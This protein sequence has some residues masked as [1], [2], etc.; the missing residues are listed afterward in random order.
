MTQAVFLQ[1]HEGV[2]SFLIMGGGNHGAQVLVRSY[3]EAWYRE[4]RATRFSRYGDDSFEQNVIAEIGIVHANDK[5]VDSG[6]L[7]AVWSQLLLT[8]ATSAHPE[9]M[10]SSVCTGCRHGGIWVRANLATIPVPITRNLEVGDLTD[11]ELAG[12]PAL[13]AQSLALRHKANAA[14]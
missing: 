4:R 10:V 7:Q 14:P 6:T 1:A 12:L 13:R 5:P 8:Q 11:A 3:T 2:F 9:W